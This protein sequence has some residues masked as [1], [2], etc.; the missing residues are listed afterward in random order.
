MIS[1]KNSSEKPQTSIEKS[2]EWETTNF[3]SWNISYKTVKQFYLTVNVTTGTSGHCFHLHCFTQI[4][5]FSSSFF[6]GL[7]RFNFCNSDNHLAISPTKVEK[8][9]WGILFKMFCNYN[10]WLGK[11]CIASAGVRG[12]AGKCRK[13]VIVVKVVT[14]RYLHPLRV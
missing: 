5:F 1:K 11:C 8:N 12:S 4:K 14:G 2:N 10:R 6:L 9:Y 7:E 13:V 3:V